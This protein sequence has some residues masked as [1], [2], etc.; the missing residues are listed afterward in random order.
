VECKKAAPSMGDVSQLRHYLERLQQ[1]SGR[2]PRGILVH[3]GAL[4][5]SDSVRKEA[6]KEPPIEIVR[7]AL[8]VDFGRCS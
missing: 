3:G 4:K 6:A 7:Y 1:E 2:S 5:L 8:R